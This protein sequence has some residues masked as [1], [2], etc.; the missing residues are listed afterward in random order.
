[1]G[2]RSKTGLSLPSTPREILTL[3]IASEAGSDTVFG[4]HLPVDKQQLMSRASSTANSS[5]R[6]S[7]FHALALQA[8]TSYESP[9][10]SD[11]VSVN[12]AQIRDENIETLSI[13]SLEDT[14][15]DATEFKASVSDDG[16]VS[17]G[18]PS[19]AHAKI[20][21]H[22]PTIDMTRLSLVDSPKEC[23]KDGVPYVASPVPGMTVQSCHLAAPSSATRT[24]PPSSAS[25]SPSYTK[26]PS[27]GPSPAVSS[28]PITPPM[29]PPPDPI[30]KCTQTT[31]SVH[32][33]WVEGERCKW[34]ELPSGKLVEVEVTWAP[35]PS[36]FTVIIII[37]TSYIVHVYTSV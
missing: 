34:E 31:P 25:L 24:S 26:S 1:M 36:N 15:R 2:Q 10:R 20:N 33:S 14:S 17:P 35:S 18:R 4:G 23:I 30:S 12:S 22:S 32:G 29:S 3:E 6:S 9:S 7:P 13:S 37:S 19:S 8:R 11:T 16:K 27:P 21:Q 5:T 28:P